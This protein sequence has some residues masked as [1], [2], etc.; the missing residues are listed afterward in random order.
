MLTNLLLTLI[1]VTQLVGLYVLI[2][3]LHRSNVRAMGSLEREVR[4]LR[5]V[6]RTRIS[7][8]SVRTG[9]HESDEE[10]ELVR[11]GRASTGKRMV[12]GGEEDSDLHQRLTRGSARGQG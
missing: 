3:V 10:R 8:A 7:T 2:R 5:L 1:W 6:S 11:L 9:S 12:F 4:D